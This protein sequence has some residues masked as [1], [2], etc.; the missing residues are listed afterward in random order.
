MEQYRITT[1]QNVIIY[2]YF[3][4]EAEDEKEAMVIFDH[5]KWDDNQDEFHEEDIIK[6]HD[7]QP[8]E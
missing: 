3:D 7:L 4:I 5:L 6:F 1:K 8:L 2:R